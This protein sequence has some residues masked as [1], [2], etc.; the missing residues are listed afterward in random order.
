MQY[1]VVDYQSIVDASHSLRFDAEF[2]RPDYLQVQRRLEDIGSRKLIDFQV[3]IRHPKEIKRNYVDNGVLLL[4]GQN[5]RPLSIDLTANPVYISEEDAE[6]LKEN[7]IHYK[8]ILIMRSGANVGQCAIYLENNPAISMSDTLIIRSENLNPFLLTIFLNTKYGEALVERGK[9]GS[10]QPHIAPSFLYQIPAPNWENLQMEIERTYLRSKELTELSKTRYTE[11]QVL[12]L[13]EL[14]LV[15]WQPKHKLAFTTDYASMQRAERIDAD[16]FQPKYDDIISAIKRYPGGWDTLGN[17]AT[18]K[19]CVEVGSKE[20]LET[21]VPFVRVSNLS[22][23]EITQEK[24][25]SEK[26]YGEITEHQPKQG[27]ILLSKDA[28]PGIAYYLREVPEK[29][30]PAGGILRLKSKTDKIGNEYLTLVLNSILTQEQ[31]NRDVGGSVILHWRPDQVAGTVIPILHQEKQAEIQQKVI[32]S[33][34]LRK[35]AKDLL[36]CAKCTV[37]IAIEQD[38]K[39]AMD[40]LASVSQI[41]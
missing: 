39:T 27:E 11:T 17:L 9:Y 6:R 28:T 20:Y 18:L 1:S 12:L 29:M 41:S 26:L 5:V 19:K 31:I 33:F 21:G 23:F 3:N 22:P 36:E 14:G 25:I 8:D 10:A 4:R 15:D 32:E 7:T 24:Y 16:Y 13:S 2:F 30:I 35:H 38:E 40:W 37:E 34:K